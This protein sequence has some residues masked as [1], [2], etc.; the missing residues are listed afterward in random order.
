[1]DTN[2]FRR[3]LLRQTEHK[4]GLQPARA[5][6]KITRRRN[7]TRTMPYTRP[8]SVCRHPRERGSLVPFTGQDH[9]LAHI[10]GA[11]KPERIRN[12]MQGELPADDCF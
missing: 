3:A 2:I 8:N 9:Y 10:A 6:L 1:M 12:V 5:V 7:G 11:E 4:T